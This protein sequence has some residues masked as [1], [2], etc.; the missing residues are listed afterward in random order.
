MRALIQ[1]VKEARVKV[2]GQVIGE[3]DRG[4]LV[5]LGVSGTDTEQEADLVWRKLSRLRIFA[6]GEGKTNLDIKQVSG[7]ILI[8]SQFTLYADC[9]KGNRPSFT[10]AGP[11][12]ASNQLYQYMLELARL[13][14]PDVQSG[15]FGADMQVELM[16]D[17]PF[18]ILLD[19]DQL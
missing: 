16:N 9:K 8:I 3:I 2:D 7:N 17:G 6:D 10:K 13:D 11:A 18:T 1:R 4:L 5:F 15:R 12:E 14:F 19:S